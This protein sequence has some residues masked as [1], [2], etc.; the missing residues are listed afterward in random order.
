MKI[1]ILELA[2]KLQ[3]KELSTSDANIVE[4]QKIIGQ[5]M[6][7]DETRQELAEVILIA[8]EDTYNTFDISPRLFDVKNFSLSDQPTFKTKKKGIK[9]YWAAPNSYAPKSRNYNSEV[10]MDF[11][12]LTVRPEALLSE[13]QTGRLDSLASLVTDGKDAIE[14]AILQRVYEVLAQAYNATSNSDNYKAVNALDATAL[15]AA[16]SHVRK[17]VGGQP[18]IIADYDIC[19]LIESFTG[20]SALEAVYTEIRDKGVL[21]KYRGCDIIYMPEILDPVTQLSIVPTDKLMVVGQ[22]IGYAATQ[23][24]STVLQKQNID[25]KSWNCRIDKRIGY[26]VTKPEGLYVI[27]ITG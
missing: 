23:G 19:T 2:E 18:T 20:F 26:C 11:E 4:A 15:N 13:L 16:I 27:E 1:N 7:T 17:K 21:G 9:A 5:M 25:D 3:N 24:D 10:T 8:L 22:K 6:K 14:I 12:E